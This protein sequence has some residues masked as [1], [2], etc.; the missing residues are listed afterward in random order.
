[1]GY[2]EK[3]LIYLPL[4]FLKCAS[5]V[6]R[7]PWGLHLDR[8]PSY[9]RGGRK[10]EEEGGRL[11][12]REREREKYWYWCHQPSMGKAGQKKVYENGDL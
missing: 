8:K 4:E 2:R 1:M 9:S 7:S 11:Y 10:K 5:G 3:H 12:S 6:E